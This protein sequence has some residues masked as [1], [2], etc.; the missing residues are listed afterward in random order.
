MAMSD[1]LPLTTTVR[2]R[3]MRK[4]ARKCRKQVQFLDTLLDEFRLF[5]DDGLK[6]Y[7]FGYLDNKLKNKPLR[8][9]FARTVYEYVLEQFSHR[10]S[11]PSYSEELYKTYLPFLFEMIITLQYLDNQILDEKLGVSMKIKDK[12]HQNLLSANVIRE[13]IYNY[14]EQRIEP[15]IG[16]KKCIALNRLIRRLLLTVDIGQRI[17]KSFNTYSIYKK[18]NSSI[19]KPYSKNKKL[20]T[21]LCKGPNMAP[22]EFEWMRPLIEEVKTNLGQKV[23]FTELYF[24]RIYMTNVLFFLQIVDVILMILN[25]SEK[26]GKALRKYAVFYG[27][28]LQLINDYADFAHATDEKGIKELQTVG[29]KTTDQFSDLRNRNITLP[30]IFYLNKGLNRKIERYLK[31]GKKRIIEHFRLE[32]MLD[33]LDSGAIDASEDLSKKMA[34]LARNELNMDLAA[35]KM[36]ENMTQIAN[37]NKFSTAFKKMR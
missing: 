5:E 32:I 17:D 13:L 27:F 28:S 24:R 8:A 11:L 16:T 19:D 22:E 34:E 15:I 33:M 18:D 25:I 20:G 36:L 4:T 9:F 35:A 1:E 7:M 12:L 23:I 31:T 37:G 10:K 26:R 2:F 30:L 29:R 21:L 14:T 6:K 3:E